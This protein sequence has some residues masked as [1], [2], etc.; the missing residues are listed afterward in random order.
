MYPPGAYCSWTSNADELFLER[1]GSATI[2]SWTARH[3]TALI[4][5]HYNR[6]GTLSVFFTTYIY[7]AHL[8]SVRFE[9]SV[10][11]ESLLT[12]FNMLLAWLVEHSLVHWYQQW[13]TVSHVPNC[14]SYH[15]TIGGLVITGRAHCLS[16]CLFDYI[17]VCMSAVEALYKTWNVVS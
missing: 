17:C 13:V 10:C 4:V 2:C 3:V 15:E 9:H 6:E 12:N 8:T 1:N 14:M 16:F 7:Y 5:F 11:H